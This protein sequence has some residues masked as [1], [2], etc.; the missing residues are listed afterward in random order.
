MVTP[1]SLPCPYRNAASMLHRK[2]AQAI[3]DITV[4]TTDTDSPRDVTDVSRPTNDEQ[5]IVINA[6]KTLLDN[7]IVKPLQVFHA[8]VINNEQDR[9]IAKATS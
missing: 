5:E 1:R 2:T 7:G 6:L 9:C 3:R 8:L 4:T